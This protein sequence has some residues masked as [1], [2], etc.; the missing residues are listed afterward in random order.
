MTFGHLKII[1]LKVDINSLISHLSTHVQDYGQIK[2][3]ENRANIDFGD[4]QINQAQIG[5]I[6]QTPRNICNIQ[7]QLMKTFRILMSEKNAEMNI[8]GCIMLPNGH[9]L[10]MNCAAKSLNEYTNTGVYIREIPVSGTP[11]DIAIINPRCIV[12]SYDNT[13]FFNNNE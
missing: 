4:P 5:T 10:M 1:E 2:I 7:L 9:L 3:T 12:V 11:F 6:V 13:N 8:T